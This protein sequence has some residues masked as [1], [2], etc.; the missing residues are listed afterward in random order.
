MLYSF[1]YLMYFNYF[2]PQDTGVRQHVLALVK[3]K[4]VGSCPRE[5]V[6]SKKCKGEKKEQKKKIKGANKQERLEKQGEVKDISKL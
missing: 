3:E 5:K 4:V 6:M 1:C 2:L